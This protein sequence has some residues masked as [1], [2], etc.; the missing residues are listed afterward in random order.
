M[1]SPATSVTAN[2]GSAWRRPATACAVALVAPLAFVRF[3]WTAHAFVV[4]F[5]LAVLVA[6]AVIDYERRILPNAIVV[7]A[8]LMVLVAQIAI[9]P[10]RTTEWVACAFG[11]AGAFLV[12]SLV[13]P[14][15]M[16]MGDVKLAFLLGAALGG[17]VLTA[18]LIASLS[19]W[20]LAV[21][22]FVKHGRAARWT[23]IAFGPFLAFGAIV[24]ALL[25]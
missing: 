14:A 25:D 11:A 24:A 3:G 1:T 6:L 20:P 8:A 19:I 12:L 23:P 16:G 22:L 2:W 5:L 15:G 21:V 4:A 9:D 17:H 18:L 7:P 13:N 10:G